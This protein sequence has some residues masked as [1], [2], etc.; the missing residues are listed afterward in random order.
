MT[1]DLWI[2]SPTITIKKSVKKYHTVLYPFCE[3]VALGECNWGYFIAPDY[4]ILPP[5][6]T[7]KQQKGPFR[8]KR[9]FFFAVVIVCFFPQGSGS[10]SASARV[11][12]SIFV[13]PERPLSTIISSPPLP[14]PPPPCASAGVVSPSRCG[15]N[16]SKR[17]VGQRSAGPCDVN[18]GQRALKS[19]PR[20]RKA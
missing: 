17:R 20:Y 13:F 10:A 3:F 8:N 14:P 18:C 5:Q 19:N 7:T 1:Y 16:N 6:R 4:S 15:R 11:F 2:Q 12:F 9:I